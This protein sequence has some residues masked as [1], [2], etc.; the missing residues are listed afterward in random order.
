MAELQIRSAKDQVSAAEWEARVNLAACY[1]L[2]ALYGMT[3]MIANH[4]SVR[5]P[6][7][8]GHFLI[9][10]YGMLYEEITASSLYKIDLDGNVVFKPDV[11]YG[12]NRAGFVIHSAIHRARHE[13]DC[14]I[15]THT[16]V[17]MA[18]SSLKSGLLPMTQ[19]AMRFARAAYH[20]YEGVAV[21]LDEQARLVADLGDADVMILRN[22]GLLAVGP[23]IPEAFSNIYRLELSC[24]AQLLAQAAN[25]EIT[26]PPQHVIEHT[27]HLYKPNVRRPF[28]ILE[29]PALLRQLDR[30][31][32]SYRE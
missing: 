6:G 14:I 9:N 7:E 11:E 17:G 4:I 28:G 29:W 22:H 27:N 10:A 8:P 26:L 21:D 15:H 19:T 13:V 31:D 16:P 23:S 24:K 20:A 5:V 12:I 3:D 25:S 18:V 30:R 2:V 32:T 1:R